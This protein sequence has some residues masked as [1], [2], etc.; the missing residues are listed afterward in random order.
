MVSLLEPQW[1][2]GECLDWPLSSNVAMRASAFPRLLDQSSP[3][4]LAAAPREQHLAMAGIV[5]SVALLEGR[6]A[7]PSQSVLA[8]KH[9]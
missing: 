6:V 8:L 5:N 1:R 3:E 4:R 9:V 7:R 2:Q